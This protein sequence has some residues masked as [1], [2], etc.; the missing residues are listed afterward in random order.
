ME[1][2]GRQVERL[3]M[4]NMYLAILLNVEVGFDRFFFFFLG[5]F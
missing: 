1:I 4:L 5:G 2:N 3:K